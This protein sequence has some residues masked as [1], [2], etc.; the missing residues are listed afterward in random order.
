MHWSI[1]AC[2][3]GGWLYCRL[4][5][6]AATCPARNSRRMNRS[7]GSRVVLFLRVVEVV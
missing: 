6:F 5:A 7:P 1:Y 4:V 3:V 2:I